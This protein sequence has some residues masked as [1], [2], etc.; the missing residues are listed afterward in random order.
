[1]APNAGC[2][3]E[4]CDC[5][6]DPDDELVVAGVAVDEFPTGSV[7]EPAASPEEPKSVAFVVELV[8]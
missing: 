1:L 2:A 6:L 5:W 3:D 8:A 4:D 7:E